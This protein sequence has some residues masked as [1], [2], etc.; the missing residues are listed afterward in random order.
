[1]S[2]SIAIIRPKFEKNRQIYITTKC[3]AHNIE[4]TS[5]SRI[6]KCCFY[7]FGY[8]L[9]PCNINLAILLKF[10]S[11]YCYWKTHKTLYFS[12]FSFNFSF[13]LHIASQK[14]KDWAAVATVPWYLPF[15]PSFFIGYMYNQKKI[16]LKIKYAKIK[17][18]I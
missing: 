16:I 17:C 12:T 4:T 2:F 14:K 18:Q 9:E 7:I 1:V 3:V 15:Q 11:N 10:R 5:E 6:L 13:W 8:T